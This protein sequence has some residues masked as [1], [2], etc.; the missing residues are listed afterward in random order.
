M[1]STP[2]F[3]DRREEGGALGFSVLLF[4][5]VAICCLVWEPGRGGWEEVENV[6]GFFKTFGLALLGI[7]GDYDLSFG[8][9]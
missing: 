5:C 9:S 7:F 2:P 6:G 3:D 4:N 1:N 8:A